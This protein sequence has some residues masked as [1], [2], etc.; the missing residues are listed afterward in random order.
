[1]S[2]SHT[3]TCDFC[4]GIQEGYEH[5]CPLCGRG[6]RHHLPTHEEIYQEAA[7]IRTQWPV[8]KL[9]EQEGCGTVEI[10]CCRQVRDGML[11]REKWDGRAE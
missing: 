1:M 7:K 11:R 3:R 4:V 5:A 2:E 9:A 6:L 8:S 10:V